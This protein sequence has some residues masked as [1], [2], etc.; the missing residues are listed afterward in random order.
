MR[1][2]V[3]RAPSGAAFGR[4][5]SDNRRRN[6]H[7]LIAR[8][9]FKREPCERCYM[10]TSRRDSCREERTLPG[11][12]VSGDA[13]LARAWSATRD[14]GTLIPARGSSSVQSGPSASPTETHK[15]A[16]AIPHTNPTDE[17]AL[18]GTL[19]MS[20]KGTEYARLPAFMRVGWAFGVFPGKCSQ[21]DR[22]PV[23][24]QVT[25]CSVSVPR[26]RVA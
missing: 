12:S 2:E 11:G 6:P 5:S 25:T 18:C 20:V 9:Q 8:L 4:T 14:C 1:S 17:T 13:K 23:K 10:A 24:R 15:S 22:T 26:S 19:V 16:V 3:A 7:A 21:G